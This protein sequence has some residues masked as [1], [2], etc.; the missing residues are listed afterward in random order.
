MR[1]FPEPP[2]NGISPREDEYDKNSTNK[3]YNSHSKAGVESRVPAR[4]FNDFHYA[5]SW[6]GVSDSA[7]SDSFRIRGRMIEIELASM[8]PR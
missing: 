1:Q 4:F 2:R 7:G 3:E 8:G 5:R 6:H